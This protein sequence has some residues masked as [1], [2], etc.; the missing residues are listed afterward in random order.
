MQDLLLI[1]LGFLLGLI[2]GWWARR[3]RLKVHWGALLAEITIC[4][5][6]AKTYLE[7]SVMAPLYRL[8][9]KAYEA[10]LPVLLSEAALKVGD[11]RAL[12]LYYGQIEDFNRGLDN[13]AALA[14]ENNTGILK[15]EYKRN[16]IKA[17]QLVA[18]IDGGNNLFVEARGSIQCHLE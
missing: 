3:S 15:T 13:A 7:D 2:P 18:P 1:I 11:V 12:L 4:S 14:M 6:K 16:C 9:A 8:P 5:E 17:E 10:S